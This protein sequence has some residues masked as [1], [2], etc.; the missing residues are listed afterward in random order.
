LL[1]TLAR[2]VVLVHGQNANAVGMMISNQSHS[3]VNLMSGKSDLSKN[4][5]TARSSHS[6]Y[7]EKIIEHL[8][9][10]QVLNWFWINRKFDLEVLRSEVDS[11]GF[12]LVLQYRNI[13]RH[14]QLKSSHQ[15]SKTKSQKVNLKLA[16]RESG[17]VIWI[18]YTEVLTGIELK[19]YGWFGAVAGK[20]LPDL[21]SKVAKNTRANSTGFKTSRVGIRTISKSKF[22]ELDSTEDLL[23]KLFNL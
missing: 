11:G 20:P 13:T 17:C 4:S 15:G 6:S 12:D 9:I 7:L 22:E 18:Q 5:T 3:G 8:F 10:G 23:K 19:S 14:I 16:N 21:G 1:A 2:P